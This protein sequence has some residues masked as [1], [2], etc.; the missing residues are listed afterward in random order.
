MGRGGVGIVSGAA[1]SGKSFLAG[2]LEQEARARGF[3]TGRARF[4]GRGRSRMPWPWPQ[5]LRGLGGTA[6]TELARE[7]L[8]EGLESPQD[9]RD[10]FL[11]SS[12]IGAGRLVIPLVDALDARAA[13]SPL[14]LVF[15][16]AQDCDIASAEVLRLVAESLA[17]LPCLILVMLRDDAA[18][19][20]GPETDSAL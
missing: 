12:G 7:L 8:R 10:G 4:E 14:L 13:E 9:D 16:D 2:H 11:A 15:D 18:A 5:I 20:V 1:G 3:A 6:T 17:S 19:T